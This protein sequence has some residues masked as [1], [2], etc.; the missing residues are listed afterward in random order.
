MAL[1]RNIRFCYGSDA[2][3]PE[4]VGVLLDQ[5]ETH[6]VY[7]TALRRWETEGFTK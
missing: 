1:E 5:L 2:H 3:K 7:G 4:S 6:P